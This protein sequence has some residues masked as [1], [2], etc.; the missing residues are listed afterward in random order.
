MS[1]VTV[2]D[3]GV[4]EGVITLPRVGVWHADLTIN[5]DTDLDGAV[6]IQV[7]G[8]LTLVG[9]V[10]RSALYDGVVRARIVGGADGL[11]NA[12]KPKFYTS[13]VFRLPLQDLLADAGETLSPT[14]DATITGMQLL[15][16]TTFGNT[17]SNEIVALVDGAP[18]GTAWRIL[19]DGSF[20]VGPETWPESEITDWRELEESPEG[21]IL[22]LGLDDP[23]LLPGT[24]LGGR[25]VECVRTA[26][27]MGHARSTVW[28]SE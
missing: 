19:P 8:T 6:T 7:G 3:H 2:N 12:A 15:H 26:F 28:W 27:G 25:Q 22:E 11:R 17:T 13:P 4:T 14:A 21:A 10:R 23:A 24:T 5:R 18:A 9:T 16:W 20:W 1:Q